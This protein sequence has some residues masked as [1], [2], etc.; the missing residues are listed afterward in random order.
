MR[1]P[2]EVLHS[3]FKRLRYCVEEHNIAKTS[4]NVIEVRE[5]TQDYD[6]LRVQDADCGVP[7]R[8]EHILSHVDQPPSRYLIPLGCCVA[9]LLNRVE[10]VIVIGR[11]AENVDISAETASAGTLSGNVHLRHLFPSL[12]LNVE[13]VGAPEDARL[14]VSAHYKG[15]LL[16]RHTT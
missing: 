13:S 4:D 8:D 14:V 12:V 1:Q 6:L 3:L 7:P 15:K 2:C 10:N 5:A 11:T 16:R 9:Q